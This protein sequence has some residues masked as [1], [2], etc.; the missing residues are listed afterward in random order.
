MLEGTLKE[1]QDIGTPIDA[2]A[3]VAAPRL[4]VQRTPARAVVTIPAT[5]RDERTAK[6]AERR[7]QRGAK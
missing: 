1:L 6:R 3:L 4:A 7:A 2:P 5:I